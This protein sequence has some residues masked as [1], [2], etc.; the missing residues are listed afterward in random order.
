MNYSGVKMTLFKRYVSTI[1][2]GFILFFAG[3]SLA[4]NKNCDFSEN[5]LA[6]SLLES[7]FSD[8][9]ERLLGNR[10]DAAKARKIMANVRRIFLH[11]Q[12]QSILLYGWS[13]LP[14]ELQIAGDKKALLLAR[15]N[16]LRGEAD[17]LG[18]R[19]T[20]EILPGQ[21]QAASFQVIYAHTQWP[22]RELGIEVIAEKDCW[23]TVKA[24]GNRIGDSAIDKAFLQ[25]LH[26]EFA[27]MRSFGGNSTGLAFLPSL[28]SLRPSVS[29]NGLPTFNGDNFW[30]FALPTLMLAFLIA[31]ILGR[32]SESLENRHATYYFRIMLG[33]WVLYALFLSLLPQSLV[34]AGYPLS[35]EHFVYA[36]FMIAVQIL[37]L[38]LG[39]SMLLPSVSLALGHSL[40]TTLF[41]F[42]GF[43]HAPRLIWYDVGLMTILALYVLLM[44][45]RRRQLT[46]RNKGGVPNIID[47][48]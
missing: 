20:F 34:P 29:F 1:A 4:E 24:G 30:S 16:K 38:I 14:P 19:F 39:Q 28:D 40:R 43:E 17:K 21:P 12:S 46:G 18:H 15:M 25:A 5:V 36:A 7:G 45:F 32:A 42:L 11:N 33:L 27:R 22:Q 8:G 2:I 47:R 44:S 6:S 10:A 37:G 3:Q 48:S 9:T 35:L 41:T 26:Q 31:I 23:L 13:E